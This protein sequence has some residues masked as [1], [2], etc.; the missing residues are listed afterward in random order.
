MKRA[1]PRLRQDA[2][3]PAAEALQDMR[4][5][6]VYSSNVFEQCVLRL[7]EIR[8]IG[9]YLCGGGGEGRRQSARACLLRVG[10][11]G[12]SAAGWLLVHVCSGISSYLCASLLRYLSAS[13]CLARGVCSAIH[14][15]TISLE[16]Q[17]QRGPDRG[18]GDRVGGGGKESRALANARLDGIE[19]APEELK[20]LHGPLTIKSSNNSSI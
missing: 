8:Q 16:P 12:L 10:C 20:P 1:N 2:R 5:S 4:V 3:I 13:L 6:T 7:G 9:E 17:A 15:L 14:L 18:G 19:P 11:S